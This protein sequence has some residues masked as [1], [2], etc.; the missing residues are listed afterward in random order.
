MPCTLIYNAI[1]DQKPFCWARD[2]RFKANDD[3]SKF[4]LRFTMMDTFIIPTAN[5][6]DASPQIP[7]LTL[8]TNHDDLQVTPSL[9]H[10]HCVRD[11]TTHCWSWRTASTGGRNPRWPPAAPFTELSA[12]S[13]TSCLMGNRQSKLLTWVTWLIV[14]ISTNCP[15][16]SFS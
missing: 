3:A 4:C 6:C 10:S 2:T 1:K 14:S 12:I 9:T 15:S 8:L 5:H 16:A 11:V 13:T 7:A